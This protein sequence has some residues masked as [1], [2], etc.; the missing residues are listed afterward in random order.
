[1]PKVPYPILILN[2][3]LDVIMDIMGIEEVFS[4]GEV[5]S[6]LGRLLEVVLYHSVGI[7]NQ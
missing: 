1:M 2:K 7:S 6:F 5:P 4:I 3:T